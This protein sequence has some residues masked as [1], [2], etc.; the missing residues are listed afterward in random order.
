M[1]LQFCK[2]FSNADQASNNNLTEENIQLKI[3]FEQLQ[4]RHSN[5]T[6]QK[7]LLET[8]FKQL[9]IIYKN[10]TEDPEILCGE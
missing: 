8:S 1:D 4:I 3:S 9:Q 7:E 5:L 2:Y 6:E 10:L